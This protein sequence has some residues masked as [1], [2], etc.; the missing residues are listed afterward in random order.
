M[1]DGPTN[2]SVE[3]TYGDSPDEQQY[4]RA[5]SDAAVIMARVQF[6]RQAGITFGGA[7]DFYEIFGYDRIITD[8]QYRDTYARGG[9]AGRIVDA[10]PNATWRG[11]VEVIEDEDPDK[12]TAFEKAWVD[13]DQR[14][15]IQA[16]LRRV[17]VLSGLSTYAVL[18]LG[19]PG[20]LDTPMPKGNPGQLIYLTPFAGGGGPGGDQRNRAIAADADATIEEFE[21]D[22]TSP[23][24]GLPKTYRLRRVDVASAQLQ[25]AVHWTRVLHVAEGCLDNDVYGAPALERVW[26]LLADLDKVTGGGAEAFWLRAN[27]GLHIDVDKDMQAPDAKFAIEALKEQ[28]EAYKHQ[29]DRWLRTKG[30]DVKVLGSDVANFANPADAIL[31]QIAGA[32]AIPKRI[33]TGS[34]M[35]ELASSQD[36]DNWRDQI[37]GR[38]TSYAAPYIMRPLVDRLIEH[39]YLPTPAKGK[40][41]YDIRWPHI[42][43]LTEQERTQGAQAWAQTNA[44]MGEPVFT[45][46]EIREKWADKAPLTDEQREEILERKQENIKLQQEAMQAAQPLAAD[47]DEDEDVPPQFKAA[48]ATEDRELLR[49]LEEALRVGNAEVVHR[50]V[51]LEFNPD[52]PRDDDGKWTGGGG[53]MPRPHGGGGGSKGKWVEG[54]DSEASH[55][56]MPL[57]DKPGPGGAVYSIADQEEGDL[58]TIVSREKDNSYYGR[59]DNFDFS[60]KTSKEMRDKL[61]K[62]GARYIG[63]ET[64]D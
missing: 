11:T 22:T 5:L 57:P 51:G 35:G 44:T 50:I 16:K 23:R 47:D 53:G 28:S 52:Q 63:W 64:K 33:L 17:D 42:Q 31:T 38:Q 58:D 25:K 2:G 46:A 6:A 56:D 10:L 30:T 3:A 12:E 29:L 9:I 20:D 32:K 49:I 26:N 54:K 18:L 45:E 48:Q 55:P 41:A 14:L 7:R 43:T 37:N 1:V 61:K 27:Q 59:A 13:L 21:L 60:A 39:G 40:D 8:R 4:L 24:F 34:E 15:Q 36:R 62:M 19:V